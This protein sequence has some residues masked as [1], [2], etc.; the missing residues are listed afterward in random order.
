M[1]NGRD[2][3]RHKRDTGGIAATREE[4]IHGDAEQHE[5]MNAAR[6]Q[7]SKHSIRGC[8]GGEHTG[9]KHLPFLGLADDSQEV[10]LRLGLKEEEQLQTETFHARKMRGLGKKL[11]PLQL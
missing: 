7:A 1:Q 6:K 10:A 9:E 3:R 8:R 11:R 5:T 4:R 2:L